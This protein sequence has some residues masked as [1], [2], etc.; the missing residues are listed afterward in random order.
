MTAAGQDAGLANADLLP[1]APERRSWT[2]WHIASL[3]IGMSECIP[4]YM[5]ASGLIAGGMNWWQAVGTILLGNLFVLLPMVLNAHAGARY[6]IP[7]PV[8]V[9]ASFGVQGANVPAVLRALVACGWFGIQTWVG[10]QGVY[11]LTGRLFGEG[12]TNA[13]ELGDHPWTLWLSFGLFWLVQ[14]A[15]ILWGMEGVRRVQVWAAPLMAVGGVALLVWMATEAGGFGPMLTTE[16][17]MGWGPSFWLLFFPALMGVIGYWATLTLNI[18]DFTR[19]ASSQRAQVVGQSLGLPTTIIGFS[20]A[21]ELVWEPEAAVDA[22][23]TVAADTPVMML[24]FDELPLSSLLTPEGEVFNGEVRQV[25]TRTA[26]GEIGILANHAPVMARLRPT[27]LRLHLS[28]SEVRRYA[29]GEGWLEVR[30]FLPRGPGDDVILGAEGTIEFFVD[31]DVN[32]SVPQ[33]IV[34]HYLDGNNIL[35]PQS[36]NVIFA[37]ARYLFVEAIMRGCSRIHNSSGGRKI[38]GGRSLID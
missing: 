30:A 25:S 6:G 29:Q 37:D 27:E 28:E 18:S 3:W 9:R 15:I 32:T 12:W 26:V 21:A 1:V 20:D 17:S 35:L 2:W 10:G 19:F 24:V 38:I 5:L 33:R 11:V 31:D 36:H 8:L 34:S 23:V 22:S 16:N 7:F 13:A 4:T 14:V